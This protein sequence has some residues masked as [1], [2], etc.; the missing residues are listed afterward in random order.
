MYNPIGRYHQAKSTQVCLLGISSHDNYIE[1][2][3]LQMLYERACFLCRSVLHDSSESDVGGNTSN[4]YQNTWAYLE[5]LTSNIYSH[6]RCRAQ[7]RRFRC[8]SAISTG[9]YQLPRT[10]TR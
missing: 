3:N 6:S 1:T 9:N 5:I 10:T 4:G 7:H 8:A 2:N